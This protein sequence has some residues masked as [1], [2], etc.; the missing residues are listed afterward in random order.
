MEIMF[1]LLYTD[2][3]WDTKD[4]NTSKENKAFLFHGCELLL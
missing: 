3:E 4:I 1:C 2:E